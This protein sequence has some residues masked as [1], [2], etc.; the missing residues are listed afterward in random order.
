MSSSP[1]L[2]LPVTTVETSLALFSVGLCLVS[3]GVVLASLADA[4]VSVQLLLH[5]A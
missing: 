1:G 4:L 3:A 5:L 2:I